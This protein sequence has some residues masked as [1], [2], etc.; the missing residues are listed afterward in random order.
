MYGW[1]KKYSGTLGLFAKIYI[2][3]DEYL[4]EPLERHPPSSQ[5]GFWQ[6]PKVEDVQTVFEGKILPCSADGVSEI[7]APTATSIYSKY[8]LKNT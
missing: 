7:F 2:G 5:N 6:H 1:R 4:V 3:D 8:H